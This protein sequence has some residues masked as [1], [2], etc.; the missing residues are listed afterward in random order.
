MYFHPKEIAENVLANPYLSQ[1][2][3]IENV[4]PLKTHDGKIYNINNTKAYHQHPG[5]TIHLQHIIN[6]KIGNITL[7]ND[8]LRMNY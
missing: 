5:T 6:K 4:L 3:T 8:M 1:Y 7:Q 2:L